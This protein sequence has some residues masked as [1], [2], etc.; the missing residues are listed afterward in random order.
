MRVYGSLEDLLIVFNLEL[1]E[2]VTFTTWVARVQQSITLIGDRVIFVES[3]NLVEISIL[4]GITPNR[5]HAF[6]V[7][8]NGKVLDSST[9]ND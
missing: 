1:R 4:S 5:V 8:V 9:P 2:V 6:A 7:Q 3:H